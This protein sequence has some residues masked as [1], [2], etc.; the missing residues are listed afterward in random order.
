LLLG[1]ERPFSA[2]ISKYIVICVPCTPYFNACICCNLINIVAII[3][4][5]SIP[6]NYPIFQFSLRISIVEFQ[7]CP[8]CLFTMTLCLSCVGIWRTYPFPHYYL[9]NLFVS[10]A[11]YFLSLELL[12]IGCIVV[13]IKRYWDQLQISGNYFLLLSNP[14]DRTTYMFYF[15][16]QTVRNTMNAVFYWLI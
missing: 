6:V 15:C 8:P 5:L 7:S 2:A 4:K 9:Q 14:K 10:I 11:K 13:C 16:C 12:N 1:V 3:N